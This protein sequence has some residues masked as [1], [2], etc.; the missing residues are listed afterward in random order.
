[1]GKTATMSLG[2]LS[3]HRFR[4]DD[5][6]ALACAAAR[7]GQVGLYP[8]RDENR[9]QN[10][11]ALA[12]R[13]QAGLPLLNTRR[14]IP[15]TSANTRL[16]SNGDDPALPGNSLPTAIGNLHADHLKGTLPEVHGL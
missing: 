13:I 16:L 5:T 8:R 12:G 9:L 3:F 4:R 6:V 11:G 7:V 2:S 1:M 10:A 14:I 15:P